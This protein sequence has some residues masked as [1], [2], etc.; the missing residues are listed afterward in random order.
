MP[1]TER[2]Q[3]VVIPVDSSDATVS[4]LRKGGYIPIRCDDP[5]RIKILL[6]S[7]EISGGDFLM[8]A[9]YGLTEPANDSNMRL[10]AKELFRRMKEKEKAS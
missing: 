10:F 4:E 1:N 2:P 9:M 8:A 5:S 6:P 3:I 7:S